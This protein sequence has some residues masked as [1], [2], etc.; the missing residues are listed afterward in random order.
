VTSSLCC[1]ICGEPRSEKDGWFLLTENRWTDRIRVLAYDPVLATQE[2]IV[3]SCSRAHV[4]E[5]VVH[6]MITGRLDYP[7][8]IVSSQKPGRVRSFNSPENAPVE[9]DTRGSRVVGELAV[10][11]ESLTRVLQENPQSLSGIL[12]AL[13]AALGSSETPKTRQERSVETTEESEELAL[14]YV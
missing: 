14:T 6:W 3:S 9:V 7:F 10:H 4:R 8:A 12:E 11:R 5:L 13:I 2:G 1:A